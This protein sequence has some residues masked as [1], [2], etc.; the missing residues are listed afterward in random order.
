MCVQA[1]GMCRA[2]NYSSVFFQI[3]W[4]GLGQILFKQNDYKDL[5]TANILLL[6]QGP[7]QAQEEIFLSPSFVLKYRV[8]NRSVH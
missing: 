3:A 7:G 5:K 6:K 4:G 8:I 2:A 1:L